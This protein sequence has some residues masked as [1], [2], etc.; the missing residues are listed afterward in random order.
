MYFSI[1][2]LSFLLTI[3]CFANARDVKITSFNYTGTRNSTAELCGKILGETK[4]MEIVDVIA[5]PSDT[6][7]GRYSTLVSSEGTFCIVINTLRGKADAKLR[8]ETT[9]ISAKIKNRL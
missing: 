7:P 4:S 1:F 6:N 8:G 3:P 9:T 5:D 2:T